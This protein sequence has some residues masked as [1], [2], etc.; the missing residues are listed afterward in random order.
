M[1]MPSQIPPNVTYAAPQAQLAVNPDIVPL[2]DMSF[3]E[4][5]EIYDHGGRGWSYDMN[6][7][8][9]NWETPVSQSQMHEIL[10]I[11]AESQGIG[12]DVTPK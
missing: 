5:S 9:G 7:V 4:H 8:N 6:A 12:W 2:Y 11:Q 10:R 3:M 1:G